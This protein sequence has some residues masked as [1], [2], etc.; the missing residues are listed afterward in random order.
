VSDSGLNSWESVRAELLRRIAERV[1]KPGERIPGEE[2]LAREFGCARATVNRAMRELTDAGLIERRRRAGS[3][4]RAR[5][6]RMATLRIPV[7]RLEVEGRG[8]VY[9]HRLLDKIFAV[10]SAS[11]AA[12]LGLPAG[13]KLLHLRSVHLGDNRPFAFEDRWLNVAAV[14]G[15]MDVDF[16]AISVNEWLVL[17]APFTGGD[18][19]FSAAAASRREAECLGIEPGLPV[20]IVERATFNNETAITSVRLAYA[21]G[22][23]MATR[24]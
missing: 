12:R 13:E 19:R 8:L 18:I 1:W 5:P 3:R 14:P 9:R 10:P 17:N 4:V 22:Y 16:D 2:E 6:D 23:S 21:P 15:V 11:L 24:I 20:F 7:I